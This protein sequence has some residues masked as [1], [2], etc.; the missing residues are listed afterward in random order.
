MI[1]T[2]NYGLK[3]IVRPNDMPGPAQRG[4]RGLP[5]LCLA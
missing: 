5:G 1:T 2:K 4:G 3:E